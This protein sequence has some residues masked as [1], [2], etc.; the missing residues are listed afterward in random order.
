MEFELN[1][2]SVT[3]TGDEKSLL[4]DALRDDF[5]LRSIKVGCSPQAGCGTCLVEVDGRPQLSCAFKMRRVEG[6]SVR[7]LEGMSAE[8]TDTLSASFAEHGGAQCGFCTPGIAMR[9][10]L[11][12]EEDPAVER[13]AV[14]RNLKQH[15]CRCTGYTKILDAVEGAGKRLRGLEDKGNADG[16]GR[17][18]GSLEK[19]DARQLTLG[20]RPFVADLRA[21]E[22]GLEG[23]LHGALVLSEHARAEVQAIDTTAAAAAPGVVRVLTAADIPGEQ[24]VGLIVN[25]WPV[26]VAV[27]ELTRYVG[28]VLAVVVADSVQ[29]ARAATEL[30]QIQYDVQKPV[31]DPEAAILPNSPLVHASGNLLSTVTLRRGDADAALAKCAHVVEHTF[32]TQRIEHAYLE[33]ECCIAAPKK[34]GVR[35]WSQSQG[36]YK[37]RAQVSRMLGLPEESVQVTLVPNGGG[38]GG[39]EDMSVQ[40]QTALA[41]YILQRPVRIELTRDESIRLSPKRHPIKMHYIVGCDAE[42]MLQVVWARMIG[43]TGAYASV[44]MKVLERAAGH[45]TGAYSVPNV[46]VEALTVYTNNLP[47][48]AF[49]GFGANQANF[50]METCVDMLAEAGGFDRWQMRWDNAL[51]RGSTT[52]TGQVL[53]GG[54]GV[55]ACLEAIEPHFRNAKFAGIAA[56]LK[57]TGVGNGKAD[58]GRAKIVVVSPTHIEVHHGWTDMGQGADTMAVQFFCNE[59]G[60][61]PEVVKVVVDTDHQVIC[62][63]TTASRATSLIGNAV[64]ETCK[65][66]NAD[67]AEVGLEGMVG[68]VYRGEWI[69]DWT[70]K[71]GANVDEVKTHYSYS[72][73]AQVAI[74]GDDG[75]IEKVVA[76]HDAGKI[77]NPMLF[78]GQIEGSVHMGLGYA[79]QEDMPCDDEGW[80]VSTRIKDCG[81]LLAHETPEIEVIGVEVA[82][83][84]GP[85]GAKGVGEIGLV[86]TAPAV[87]NALWA[88]DGERRLKL[89]FYPIK[90]R[91]R[92]KRAK[93]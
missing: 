63:M 9:A 24:Y 27:G 72:Y 7:T 71:I 58:E 78:E 32:D 82:D 2:K 57:N 10:A 18:G 25:D 8:I 38:F 19:L 86:P 93:R 29:N 76:A 16:N 92:R 65:P 62:G 51:R 85:H 54:V 53:G 23:L 68:R 31:I 91:S 36:V 84:I 14:S 75:K 88:F 90:R 5:D 34:G 83:P 26:M 67:R 60:L 59:T 44:G 35:L 46:D 79:L 48:G 3:W 61:P 69:C 87:G 50:G 20:K 47:C 56:G 12:L 89:P 13:D 1:G 52:A 21:A 77:V 80:P 81:V 55:R 17:V 41:A 73:A 45:S 42:G 43:D 28:D 15:L 70:T 30:V 37:D 22:I 4:V 33:P 39:K 11:M 6:S 66:F 74:V 40:G 64:I 49:R